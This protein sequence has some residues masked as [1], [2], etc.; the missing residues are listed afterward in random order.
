MLQQY[1]QNIYVFRSRNLKSRRSLQQKRANKINIDETAQQIQRELN[2]SNEESPTKSSNLSSK[3]STSTKTA[4]ELLTEKNICDENVFKTPSAETILS[5]R[6][7]SSRKSKVPTR[8]SGGNVGNTE[9]FS[10]PVISN[11]ATGSA[12]PAARENLKLTNQNDEKKV[13]EVLVTSKASVVGESIA[14]ELKSVDI[15][16]DNQENIVKKFMENQDQFDNLLN[17]LELSVEDD[18]TS[19]SDQSNVVIQ[20][21]QVEQAPPSNSSS[22]CTTAGLAIV[23]A[24]PMAE[25]PT[26]DNFEARGM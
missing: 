7:Q 10:M 9:V 17:L 12:S 18:L 21:D 16:K 14:N 15:T 20:F 5:P 11:I 19:A 8:K 4:G 22:T 13:I 24:S 6:K 3:P 25:S 2:K 23:D 1:R 26:F